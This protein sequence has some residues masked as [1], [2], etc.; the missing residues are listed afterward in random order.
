MGEIPGVFLTRIK[1]CF[2][3]FECKFFISENLITALIMDTS[4][5]IRI[6]KECNANSDV[7]LQ[8]IVVL[9]LARTGLRQP[10]PQA[11]SF[12]IVF[13]QVEYR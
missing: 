11:C 9:L 12:D 5:A 4:I 3:C 13:S 1:N 7:N 8:H 10:P 6:S 2:F